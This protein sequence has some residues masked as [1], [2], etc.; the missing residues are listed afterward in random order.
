MRNP[1]LFFVELM[2]QPLWIPLWVSALMMVNMASLFF[3]HEVLAQIIFITFMASAMIMM[4]L[5]SHFGFEKILGLGHI[6]W[7][8]L[9]IYIFIQI[10]EAEQ[11]FRHYLIVLSA[12]ISISLLFDAMDTF[13][14]FKKNG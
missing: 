5:Y 8:P 6:L 14:Y 12:F 13:K 9:L 3:W 10:P 1:L 4:L 7:I 11:A 2:Q